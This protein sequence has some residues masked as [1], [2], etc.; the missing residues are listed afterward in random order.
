M[1]EAKDSSVLETGTLF[2]LKRSV[3]QGTVS[4]QF[5]FKDNKATGIMKMGTTEK[6]VSVDVGGPIFGDSPG[7]AQVIATLPLAVGYTTMFRN[8]DL[9]KQK[10]K[11]QR[12]NVTGSESVTVP[13]GTFDAFKVEVKP[14]DGGADSM[15]VWVEK[16]TRKVVKMEAV[17]A[18]MGG[19]KLTTELLK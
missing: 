3:N 10:P 6:P 16:G 1:G 11:V 5:E 18:S 12:L 9:Q 8:F 4:I 19:A 2:L 13:A 15:T 17:M 14:V 7:A